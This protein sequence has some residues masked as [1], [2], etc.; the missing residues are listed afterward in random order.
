MMNIKDVVRV[1]RA[2]FLSVPSQPG[3]P[4]ASCTRQP[5]RSQSLARSSINEATLPKTKE[6]RERGT[7][8]RA[9]W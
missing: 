6:R 2:A 8:S 1:P 3:A 9:G 4:A 5:R 7:E